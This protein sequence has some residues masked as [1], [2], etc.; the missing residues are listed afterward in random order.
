LPDIVDCDTIEEDILGSL[1][2]RFGEADGIPAKADGP[3]ADAVENP[4]PD[5]LETLPGADEED[6]TVVNPP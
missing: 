3:L 5:A 6:D 4:Y 2:E 1:V